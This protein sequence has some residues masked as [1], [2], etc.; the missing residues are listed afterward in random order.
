MDLPIKPLCDVGSTRDKAFTVKHYERL[1][2]YLPYSFGPKHRSVNRRTSELDTWFE[3]KKSKS[4][5]I[6]EWNISKCN[7]CPLLI[8]ESRL[9]AKA[10]ASSFYSSSQQT[11]PLLSAK[12][13]PNQVL[14]KLVLFLLPSFTAK[15]KMGFTT[16]FEN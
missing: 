2:E 11:D 14:T 3:N 15:G 9:Y 5:A 13:W 6:E 1:L 7:K 8:K 16:V 4:N 12:P 10:T